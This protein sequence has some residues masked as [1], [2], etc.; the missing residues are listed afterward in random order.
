MKTIGK[1]LGDNGEILF[2]AT[3]VAR[4]IYV[5]AFIIPSTSETEAQ[6][7]RIRILE[8]AKENATICE[9]LGMQRQT[10]KYDQCIL[11]IGQF[12]QNVERRL[13]EIIY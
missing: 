3:L 1:R 8:A 12:R 2:R 7:Q 11:H 13:I 6:R 5:F 10:D 9:K 4:V